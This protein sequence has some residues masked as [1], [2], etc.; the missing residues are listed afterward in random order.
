MNTA[1]VVTAEPSEALIPPDVA[2][3]LGNA[4][5]HPEL[6]RRAS[7]SPA[8]PTAAALTQAALRFAAWIN[9][10]S[11]EAVISDKSRRSLL[12]RAFVQR[13]DPERAHPANAKPGH[14]SL[15]AIIHAVGKGGV[16]HLEASDTPRAVSVVHGSLEQ[17][18]TTRAALQPGAVRLLPAGHVLTLADLAGEGAIAVEVRG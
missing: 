10:A 8:T 16:L 6:L 11:L 2:A 14:F 5:I 9:A 1:P 12:E 4:R 3:V 13:A 17:R 7:Q 18:C 15:R